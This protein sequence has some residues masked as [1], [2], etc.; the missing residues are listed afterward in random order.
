MNPPSIIA[1]ASSEL[2]VLA[3]SGNGYPTRIA[4]AIHRRIGLFRGENDAVQAYNP[5][6]EGGH[7]WNIDPVAV[8]AIGLGPTDPPLAESPAD[9]SDQ[10]LAV[11]FGKW[12][13]IGTASAVAPTQRPPSMTAYEVEWKEWLALVE[14]DTP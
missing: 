6:G 13:T 2:A 7:V 4:K 1:A 11:L 14:R 9:L 3:L 8:P 12:P 5:P 10:L